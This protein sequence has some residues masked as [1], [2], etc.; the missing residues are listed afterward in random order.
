MSTHIITYMVFVSLHF[1]L[2]F[3]VVLDVYIYVYIEHVEQKN[4]QHCSTQIVVIS[5][6]PKIESHFFL[7]YYVTYKTKIQ[8]F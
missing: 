6:Y 7:V 8:H 2:H 4:L 1:F 3:T 5:G